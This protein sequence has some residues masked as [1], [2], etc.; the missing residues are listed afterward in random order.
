MDYLYAFLAGAIL[1]VQ[2]D[3]SDNKFIEET[4]IIMHSLKGIPLILLT[5]LAKDDFNFELMFTV[6]NVFSMLGDPEGYDNGFILSHFVFSIILLL[7]SFH[8]RSYFSI[9]DLFYILCF[10]SVMFLEPFLIKDEFSYKKLLSR[11]IISINLVIGIFI[12]SYFGISKSVIKN[13]VLSLG[14][15]LLSCAFQIYSLTRSPA[16]I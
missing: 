15:L 8:S 7:V 12:S 3:V 14:Y 1:K 2:D 11:T 16:T 4:G 5:L 6:M 9:Y 10:V 13:S